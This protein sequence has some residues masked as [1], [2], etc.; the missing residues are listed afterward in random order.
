M[1]GQ[2]LADLTLDQLYAERLAATAAVQAA[3]YQ[4]GLE[5]WRQAKS[6]ATWRL[7]QVEGEIGRRLAAAQKEAWLKGR[8][9]G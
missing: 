6:D 2:A 5:A 7:D 8:A 4:D 1:S 3:E 9:D